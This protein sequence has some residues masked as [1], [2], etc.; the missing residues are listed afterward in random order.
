MD[1][2]EESQVTDNETVTED[3]TSATTTATISPV[4]TPDVE[5]SET[6]SAMEHD[7]SS[8]ITSVEQTMHCD[9]LP[10]MA[11][12]SL[13]V[14]RVHVHQNSND[15]S[16]ESESI[17]GETTNQILISAEMA[18]SLANTDTLLMEMQCDCDENSNSVRKERCAEAT[19]QNFVASDTLP[20]CNK[21]GS[22]MKNQ[23]PLNGPNDSTQHVETGNEQTILTENTVNDVATTDQFLVSDDSRPISA[24][25]D[26]PTMD[27][28]FCVM[29]I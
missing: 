17:A 21:D 13:S 1:E 5:M 8:K 11:T 19:K 16:S 20:A 25:S 15:R 24:N 28:T 2:N 27:G 4:S 23:D 7:T 9:S 18:S 26:Q 6:E 22:T 3:K 14:K 10:P 29:Q 12:E